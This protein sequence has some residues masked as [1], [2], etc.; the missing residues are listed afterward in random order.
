MI[1][2]NQMISRR[3][4]SWIFVLDMLAGG[5]FSLSAEGKIIS[6]MT[7][8]LGCLMAFLIVDVYYSGFF[9]LFRYYEKKTGK[10]LSREKMPA[11]LSFLFLLDNLIVFLMLL[12]HNILVRDKLHIL[13]SLDYKLKNLNPSVPD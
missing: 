13:D 12:L 9:C 10:D 4:A 8:I 5:L 6:P 2:D 1:S 11:V 7:I 3:Q